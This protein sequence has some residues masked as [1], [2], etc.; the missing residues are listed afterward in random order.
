MTT[1][2]Y[3]F[4]FGPSGGGGGPILSVDV[5]SISFNTPIGLNPPSQTFNITNAGIGTLNWTL[6]ASGTGL[7]AVP[8]AGTAPSSVIVSQ[9]VSGLLAGIYL[10]SITITAP[11]ASGSPYVIP[12]TT[13]VGAAVATLAVTP[14]VLNY[15]A[16]LGGPNP[17]PQTIT[18]LNLGPGMFTWF[19]TPI[20]GNV[21]P[22]P[23]SGVSPGSFQVVVDVTGLTVGNHQRQISVSAVI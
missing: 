7:S 6:V 12:V 10:G 21:T 1:P 19:A 18:V 13:V 8:A 9:N 22:V 11:G 4:F 17:A 15:T 3:F 14:L 16:P 20:G 2:L 23:S 5:S